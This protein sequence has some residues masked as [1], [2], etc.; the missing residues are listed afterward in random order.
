MGVASRSQTCGTTSSGTGLVVAKDRVLTNAHVVVGASR[1]VV[2]GDDGAGSFGFVV[3]FDPRHDLAV[4]AA[5]G[6]GVSAPAF[7]DAVANGEAAVVARFVAG[8]GVTEVPVVVESRDSAVTKGIFGIETVTIDYWTVAGDID[9]GFSGA[10]LVTEHGVVGIVFAEAG[11]DRPEG[12]ALS[13]EH[14]SPVVERAAGFTIKA[15][16]GAC[17][18]P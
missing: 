3:Y 16:T 6:F 8:E 12:Y 15:D 13:L 10:P 1:T 2:T 7:G 5:P 4:I 11:D 14:V 9:P 17:L 18:V